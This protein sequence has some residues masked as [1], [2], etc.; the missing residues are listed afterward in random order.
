MGTGGLLHRH[1][2][3]GL[4]VHLICA[5]RGG[6]GWGGK[7]AG[8]RK[9]DLPRIR[10]AELEAAADVLGLS[11]VTL[12]DYPDGSVAACDQAEIAARIADA[13][14][15]LSPR[16]VIGWGPDGAYGHP[17]HIAIGACTDAAMA[18]LDG[19]RPTLYHMALDEALVQSYRD[20]LVMIGADADGLPLVAVPGA[21]PMLE[22][23]P[24]EV[25]AK[26]RAIDCHESQVEAWRITIRER[27]DLLQRVYGREGYIP[28]LGGSASLGPSGLLKEFS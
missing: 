5:T 26:R 2:A 19:E 4:E 9:E 25:D 3:S 17:D 28:S 16:V 11:Q 13:V 8:A 7:P 1:A 24:E 20:V 14:R 12:W 27:P 18:R 15:E 6:E 23:T 10:T 21:A 22:L